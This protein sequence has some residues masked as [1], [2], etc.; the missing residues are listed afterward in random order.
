MSCRRDK[1]QDAYKA[2]AELA[3]PNCPI[4]LQQHVD[5][6]VAKRLVMTLPYNSQFKSNWGYVKEALVR[7]WCRMY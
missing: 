2:V 4:H 7:G 6:K 1:P 5:R 3:K